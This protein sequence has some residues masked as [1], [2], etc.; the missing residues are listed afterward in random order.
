MADDHDVAL[1]DGL[2]FQSMTADSPTPLDVDADLL[3]WRLFMPNGREYTS[4]GGTSAATPIVAGPV[5]RTVI[6][7]A[8]QVVSTEP[9]PTTSRLPPAAAGQPRW[10][11]M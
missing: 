1:Q 4:F 11:P 6:W 10:R 3:T 7:G 5:L 9:R 2:V 8:D